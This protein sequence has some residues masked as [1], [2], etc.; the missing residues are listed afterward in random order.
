MMWWGSRPSILNFFHLLP[1]TQ[2]FFTGFRSTEDKTNHTEPSSLKNKLPSTFEP[3]K[4][5]QFKVDHAS[6]QY[7]VMNVYEKN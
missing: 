5:H 1:Q 6:P 3:E 7:Y 2:V 4:T